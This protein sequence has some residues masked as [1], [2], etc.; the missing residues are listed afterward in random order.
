MKATPAPTIVAEPGNAE[1]RAT[2]LSPRTLR[3][4]ESVVLEVR[5]EGLPEGV[6][7]SIFQGRR[8]A[9]GIRVLRVQFVSPSLVR[10]SVL[11]DP[12]LPLGGYTL[13]LR[14]RNGVASPGLQIEVVL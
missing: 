5:G 1:V 2:G 6:T 12:E 8:P 9:A 11:S 4:G 3:R 10:V 7:A 13:I 14:D